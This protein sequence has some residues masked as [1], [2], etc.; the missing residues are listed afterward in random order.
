MK[1]LEPGN[2]GRLTLKNRVVMTPMGMF[3]V[4]NPDGSLSPRGMEFYLARAEAA[5]HW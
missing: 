1:L 2:I 5:P 3:G 4:P